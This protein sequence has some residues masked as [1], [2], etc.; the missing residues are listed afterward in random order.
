MQRS[1]TQTDFVQVSWAERSSWLRLLW[2]AV[3]YLFAVS[4][5]VATAASVPACTPD[6]LD[7]HVLPPLEPATA[8]ELHVLVIEVENRGRS[9]CQL[10]GPLVELLPQSGADTFTNSFFSDQEKTKSEREFAEGQNRLLPGDTTHMLVA[11]YSLASPQSGGCINRDGLAVSLGMNQPSFVSVQHLWMRVC[12]RA[13]VSAYRVGHHKGEAVPT[14]WLKRLGGATPADF[15][16]LPFASPRN[17]HDALVVT[18]TE[19]ERVMLNDYFPLFL[20]LPHADMNCPFVVLRKREA[21][22]GTKAYINHCKSAGTESQQPHGKRT[23]W[24]DWLGPSHI[25]MQPERV[26]TVEY[27]VFSRVRESEKL[28]YAEANTSVIVRNPKSP[29]PP[30]IDSP[31]PD[32]RAAQLKATRPTVIDGGKWHDSYVYEVTNIS[33]QACIVG[34][35]PQLDFPHPPGRSFS[36]IPTPCPNCEDALFEPRPSG[37]IDLHPGEA[38]HFLVGATR[39][40]TDT[41]RWRQICTVEANVE[42]KLRSENESILL[43]FGTG[44]CAGLTVSAW[45]AGTFDGD[46]KNVAYGKQEA[47]RPEFPLAANCANANFDKLGHPMMLD[48]EGG[49]QFGLS[50]GPEKMIYG[51]PVMLHL[52]I[53]NPTDE[54]SSVMTCMTLDFFW[55]NAF[56]LYDAYGHRLV[57]KIEQE[58]GRQKTTSP[59]GGPYRACLGGWDCTRNFPIPIPAHTCVNAGTYPGYDFNRDLSVSYD[60]PPGTYYVVPRTSKMDASSCREI[61]PRLDPALL[62]DKLKIVIEQ[63]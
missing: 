17:P 49:L 36:S 40:N 8:N 43:P 24:V 1:E 51:N 22:G 28:F 33:E 48:P 31:F 21:D 3:A 6:M 7:A 39:F 57:K 42:L 52:W 47:R 27:E 5:P 37:W 59:S 44:T 55:A 23:K 50:A 30:L 11:W 16:P 46:P 34:G 18:G 13:Y 4:S 20:E 32:C 25:G 53:D 56:D 60:L 58:N 14:E 12:D 26:G 54:Q 62:R 2:V 19:Y 45:R 29:P 15:A 10:P 38:A 41:G 9:A 63:D 61:V 35:V